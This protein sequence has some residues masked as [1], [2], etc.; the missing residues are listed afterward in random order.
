MT[1]FLRVHILRSCFTNTIYRTKMYTLNI[2]F[3]Y[4]PFSLFRNKNRQSS[5]R[6]NC[7]TW[8]IPRQGIK[9]V[10]M[11]IIIIVILR[12]LQKR[13][14]ADSHNNTYNRIINKLIYTNLLYDRLKFI[15]CQNSERNKNIIRYQLYNFLCCSY[16]KASIL[17]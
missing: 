5:Y 15:S 16:R 17:R 8:V 12:P 3:I 7:L 2:A 10:F 6:V 14:T 4:I 1:L 11:H 9:V 13:C